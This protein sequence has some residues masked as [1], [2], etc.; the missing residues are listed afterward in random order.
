MR[1]PGVSEEM[2]KG[3]DRPSASSVVEGEITGLVRAVRVLITVLIAAALIAGAARFLTSAETG[4]GAAVDGLLVT[5]ASL[6]AILILLGSLVEGF[7]FGLSLGTNW[8]YTRNILVLLVRGDPEAAHRIVATLVGLIA[9]AL[10]VL[11]PDSLTING[12]ILIVLTA[13]LGVGTLHVLAGRLPSIVHGAH[14]LLAH[15]VFLAYAFALFVPEAGFW[16]HL[17]ETVPLHALL[18]AVFLGGMTTGQRGFGQPIG[19][20][21][22]PRRLPQMVLVVH[23]SAAL[24]VVGTLA[25]LM[26]QYPLAFYLAATQLLVGLALVHAVNITPKAPGIIVGLHQVMAISIVLAIVVA[27]G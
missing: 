10:V 25:W 18:L 19:A 3:T 9:V 6:A 1:S 24:A 27:S 14:G 5:Q 11:H 12:L 15:G 8:P 17:R 22:V 4:T 20:F 7:G 16:S 21:T 13:I 26:P 2:T 23:I